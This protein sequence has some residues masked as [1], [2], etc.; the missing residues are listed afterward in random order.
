MLKM[1]IFEK[2]L[3][4]DRYH[5]FETD[6]DIFKT[7]LPIFGKLT[8]FDWPPIPIFQNLLTDILTKYFC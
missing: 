7:I 3:E 6:T 4:T 8:I 2:K 1:R 5:F